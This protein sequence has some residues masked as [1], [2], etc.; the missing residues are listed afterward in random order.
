MP[1]LTKTQAIE[2]LARHA[3]VCDSPKNPKN[4]YGTSAWLQHF[5]E[6]AVSDDWTLFFPQSTGDGHSMMVLQL[7]P[8]R[9]SRAVPMANFYSSL[10]PPF[11]STAENRPGAVRELVRALA[12]ERPRLS[13]VTFAP[14]D[15]ACPDVAALERELWAAGWY[16]RR[17]VCFGNRTEP[18][19]GR[20]FDDYM[21]ERTQPA[22][23]LKKFLKM[24]TIELISRPAQVDAAMTAYEAIYAKSWKRPEPFPTFARG[25]AHRCAQQGWLRMGVARVGDTAVAA[26]IWYVFDQRAYIYKLVYDND[27]AKASAGTALTVY[28]MR[29]VWE[30]DKVI[31]ADFLS[32]DDPYKSEWMSQ[33]R[34]RIG[35]LA[36]NLRTPEGMMVATKEFAASVTAPLRKRLREARKVK[37]DAQAA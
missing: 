27:Y 31:E 21:R 19:A 37:Q 6:D 32:G 25:W 13:T 16:V 7:D 28:L 3:A 26:Q 35:L 15:A 5:V 9:P 12:S 2:Y 24:G 17:Y 30:Q 36:C 10:F 4:P 11:L 1:K 33:R 14:L 34:D 18:C 22:R 20:S 8:Q 23:K 29:H